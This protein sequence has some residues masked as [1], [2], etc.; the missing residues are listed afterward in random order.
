MPTNSQ[1]LLARTLEK[2]ESE[3]LDEWMKQQVASGL[4]RPDLSKNADE[5]SQAQRFLS[6]FR[7]GVQEGGERGDIAGSAWMGF[8][9]SSSTTTAMQDEPPTPVLA[10]TAYA[11][12]EEE[13]RVIAA[14]FDA[15]LAKPVDSRE[16]ATTLRRLVH[17]PLA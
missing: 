6:A 10:L 15:Y 1:D 5:R 2:H 13:R 8:A 14:G 4:L 12:A 17:R 11:G 9:F 16:L 3:I 7:T